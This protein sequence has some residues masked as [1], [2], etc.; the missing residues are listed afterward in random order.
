MGSTSVYD[1]ELIEV[2]EFRETLRPFPYHKR[3]TLRPFDA[4]HVS[5]KLMRFDRATSQLAS[6]LASG[7]STADFLRDKGFLK[8]E[9]R[10]RERESQ[11]VPHSMV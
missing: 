2:G 8:A 11:S 3:R 9:S 7:K 5:T 4:N 10:K 1:R 6:A